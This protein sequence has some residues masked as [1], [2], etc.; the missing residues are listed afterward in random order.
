[1]K[2]RD[3][4][5]LFLDFGAKGIGWSAARPGRFYSRK[6]PGTHCTGGWVGLMACLD[7]CKKNLAP[8][9]IRTA[10]RP[11]WSQS[12]YRLTFPSTCLGNYRTIL[13]T[14]CKFIFG[15][16]VT[17]THSVLRVCHHFDVLRE[18]LN[19]FTAICHIYFRTT[20]KGTK[21]YHLIHPFILSRNTH[22]PCKRKDSC[23]RSEWRCFLI[24]TIPLH[25][26]HK[27]NHTG[28]TRTVSCH[29]R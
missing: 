28:Y 1:M 17:S 26:K 8:T 18:L 21:A 3:I 13:Q 25:L 10:D 5:L 14:Y 27:I 2:D 19:D 9:G 12:L 24:Y 29:K 22:H 4:A 16:P 23:S 20:L 15:R 11:A 6:R 7:V